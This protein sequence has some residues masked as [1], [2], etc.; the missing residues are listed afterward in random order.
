MNLSVLKGVIKIGAYFLS[1]LQYNV[2]VYKK[3]NTRK[4]VICCNLNNYISPK[5]INKLARKS[6]YNIVDRRIK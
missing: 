1:R 6:G 5:S 4:E 3:K 2:I